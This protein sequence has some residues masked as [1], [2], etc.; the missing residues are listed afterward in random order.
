MC[1]DTAPWFRF[2]R[3]TI[4]QIILFSIGLS[5]VQVRPSEVLAGNG[6]R[7]NIL[8]IMSDD[9][10][11]Q[12]GCYGDSVVKTPHLDAFAKR[13]L[14]FERAY[15]QCAVCS[16]SRNSMLSGVR[17]NTTGLRGFGV[18]VRAVMPDIVTLPQ[19]FKQNGHHTRAFGKIFH[20][21]AES[22]L[23]SEDDPQSWSEPLQLPTVPVWGPQ[24]NAL[25]ER[26]IAEARAEG[27]QFKHP[28]DWPR[29]ETW[30][31]SDVPDDQMQDG[32]TAS[33][34]EAFLRSRAGKNQPFFA[35]VGF[36]RPHLPFNAPRKYWDLYDP[37]SLSL[38]TFRQRPKAAPPWSVTQGIVKNYYNMPQFASI[39]ETFLRRYL[40]A[41]LACISYVD[42]CVGR[43]LTAL[44]ASGHG[45]D[46]IVL[47]MGDHGYQMGEYDSWGHKHSNFEISTRAPLL[48]SAPGMK[49]AGTATRQLTEF[50][51]LYPTLCD[52]AGL[53]SPDHLEGNSFAPL[54][55]DPTAS[56]RDAACNEMVRAKRIGRS[57]RTEDFRYTEWR[58][59]RGHLVARELYDHRNDRKSGYLE[60]VN[61][62]GQEEFV[63]TIAR[64]SNRLGKLVPHQK[65]LP[66]LDK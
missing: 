24:Q 58:D 13:S 48:I 12:L 50:L 40:Q 63:E 42:A 28:H 11:P 51:D 10:R 9:L 46:T 30:D 35:A 16:P 41:Y 7:P 5:V 21:Y 34:A 14:Q 17:P 3:R 59:R 64:L 65:M 8:W 20:I 15:V 60:T 38:P 57:I 43:V 19:H 23:G 39:D 18:R 45:D 29:A 26:L 54:L 27:K 2:Y 1:T 49:R 53:A 44:E 37:D 66:T 61:V 6:R 32:N 36:L 33:M 22:M 62:E 52:L 55:I 56:H 31:D 4:L 47:F 25:R